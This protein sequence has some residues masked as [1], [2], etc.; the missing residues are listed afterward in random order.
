MS[1]KQIIDIGSNSI[2]FLISEDKEI[3]NKG[4]V[5]V[6]F[7]N[8]VNSHSSNKHIISHLM[9]VIED[10]IK[11]NASFQADELIIYAT[12]T[13]RQFDGKGT[14]I[15]QI[16]DKTDVDL[17]ILTPEEEAIFSYKVVSQNYPDIDNLI[18]VDMGGASTEVSL[19][20]KGKYQQ[21]VSLGVG[22]SNVSQIGIAKL[23]ARKQLRGIIDQAMHF[24]S[25]P[26]LVLTGGTIECL[27]RM[28]VVDLDSENNELIN[29][30]NVKDLF[31]ERKDLLH[32]Y[33]QIT[34]SNALAILEYVLDDVMCVATLNTN[35]YLCKEDLR[36]Y[37]I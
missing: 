22:T 31:L 30:H 28:D 11:N 20:I 32:E 27:H 6:G 7:Y 35:I 29:L 37:F 33:R 14:I 3:L 4:K 8:M 23:E 36:F 13:M 2:K 15:Q 19:G 1:K 34:T 12:E 21:G 24:C 10:I 25:P 17:Q 5:D 26:I 16:K 9:V 18:V